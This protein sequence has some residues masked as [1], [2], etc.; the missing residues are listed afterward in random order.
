MT[1]IAQVRD[2]LADV[3]SA[4]GLPALAYLSDTVNTP[5][6]HVYPK[7][8]DPR[9]VFSQA[10]AEY[11]F[12]VIVYTNRTEPHEAQTM[13]DLCR[14]LTGAQSILQAVQGEW[15]VGVV[16]YC[17]VTRISEVETVEVAGVSY[18]IVEFDLEIVW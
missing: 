10:K 14:E 4:T 13:L 1:T 12:G 2:A 6:A 15:T 3:V 7:A 9:L 8:M 11:P 5:C 17:T 16:D 18:L